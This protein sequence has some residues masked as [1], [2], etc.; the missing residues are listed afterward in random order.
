MALAL[1]ETKFFL[2]HG[3]GGSVPRPRL[4]EQ[5]GRGSRLTLVSAPA[6]FGKTTLVGS[7]LAE[8]AAATGARVA[9][10]SLD[11]GDREPETFWTYVLSAVDRAAPG[12]GSAGLTALGAGQPVE[13]A[14]AAVLNELSVLPDDVVLALDDYHLAEGPHTQSGMAFLIE[15]LPP[16]VRLVIS[17][18]ADPVL[19]LARLR[20]RGELTE[21]RAADLRFTDAEATAFLTAATGRSLEAGDVAALGHRT[22]GWIASL[23]L[24]AIS[25]RD[26]A[27]PSGFIA[28]FAGD[29]RYVVDYLVEEVLGEEPPEVRDFL[30]DTAVLDRLSGPLCD[31]V[32]ATTGGAAMLESLERRNLF[33]VPLDD[34]RRWYRYHHLFADM[35]QARLLQERPEAIPQLHGRASRWYAEAGQPEEAVRHALAAGDPERAADLVELALPG[36]RRERREGVIRRWVDD[37]PED[38]VRDRPVL[39]AGFIG[40]LMASNHFAGVDQRLRELEQLLVRPASELVVVDTDEL[41]R[42]PGAVETWWAGLALVG[43]DLAGTVVHARRAVEAAADGDD[44]TTSAGAALAGLAHWAGGDLEAA[45]RG[46]VTAAEGLAR[47]GHI[48]DVLGCTVTI[49][50]LELALGRLGDAERTLERALGL[51]ER[52]GPPPPAVMR[53]T[54]DMLVGLSRAAWHRND[55]DAAAGFLRRAD[56]LGESAGLPQH[57]YRW[58]V[59]LARLRTAGRD[60]AGAL[61]LLDEAERVYVGDFSPPVHPIHATRARVLLASGDIAGAAGWARRHGLTAEDELSYLREYEHLTL[62]RVLLAEQRLAGAIGLLER[63]LAAAEAGGRLGTVIEIEVV[64]SRAHTAAGEPAAALAALEHAVDLG[65]ADGWVRFVVDAGAALTPALQALA[66]RRPGSAFV[67]RLL[68]EAGP[69][70]GTTVPVSPTTAHDGGLLDPLS[71]RELDVL[72]LLASELDGPAIARELVVSLN[73]VRTHTKHIYTKLDVNNRRSAVSRAHQLGLLSRR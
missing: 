32:T 19:P 49:A 66:A 15:R 34:Q 10:L 56:E 44:V 65:E 5:L 40:A 13:V 39:A 47:A 42:L 12:A 25:L 50:D 24:A 36:L 64:R 73:T 17:T 72:R 16:Q 46:Y 67:R 41:A 63:L 35:L 23:Q 9:W 57:P 37:L 3:R 20:A 71:D 68:A 4:D 53:G 26:R 59:A 60:H 7:W 33:V 30:L 62:A 70:V 18:R 48:A 14:L 51:A 22:E 43:G 1:V 45:H 27:D 2:P 69:A 29:D 52:H 21:V 6:G 8:H 31:A 28:G 54:A 61:E 58:R 38:V 11:A 55:L